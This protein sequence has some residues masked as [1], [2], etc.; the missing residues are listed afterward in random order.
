M[1]AHNGSKDPPEFKWAVLDSYA[2]ALR[3]Q[4]GEGLHILESG[5]LNRKIEFNNNLICRMEART[6]E[7]MSEKELQQELIKRKTFNENLKKFVCEKAVTSDVINVKKRTI[8]DPALTESNN[9]LTFRSKG[10]IL[11]SPITKRKRESMDTSTPISTRREQKLIELEDDSPIGISTGSKLSDACDTSEEKIQ[12]VKNKAGMSNEIN[13]MNVTPPR[14]FSPETM[15]KRLAAHS[16][17]IAKASENNL[18]TP[19]LREEGELV[20]ELSD[21][22]FAKRDGGNDPVTHQASVRW[23]DSVN[24]IHK[25]LTTESD[26]AHGMDAMNK[27]KDENVGSEQVVGMDGM[28]KNCTGGVPRSVGMD[29][30]NKDCSGGGRGFESAEIVDGKRIKMPAKRRIANGDEKNTLK[31]TNGA[32]PKLMIGGNAGRTILAARACPEAQSPKRSVS[33]EGDVAT[34][35]KKPKTSKR[36][37][38]KSLKGGKVPVPSPSPTQPLLTSMWKVDGGQSKKEDE[39]A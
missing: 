6:D 28:N 3:R 32:F 20:F 25:S 21:N 39:D 7:R 34:P 2:D 29:E 14:D 27:N 22:P 35:N 4:L 19:E 18:L 16:F 37:S 38:K 5:A 11:A 23:P 33:K 1:E 30:M 24:E 13:S 8:V 31:K 26:S 15:D 9:L 36:L 10:K 17:I 12:D